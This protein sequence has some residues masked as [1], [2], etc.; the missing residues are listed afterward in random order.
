MLDLKLLR[1]R[2][3]AVR[4]ALA[5]RGD[6]ALLHD[7][8]AAD[9]RRRKIVHQVELKQQEHNQR[10][11][12]IGKA[13][14]DDRPALL[15]E[16]KRLK[17]EIEA[18]DPQVK[19]AEEQLDMVLAR[20][21]NLPH[22]SVPTGIS[23]DDNVE[24]RRWG[25]PT[26][27]PDTRD[28]LDIGRELGVI[29]TERAAWTSGSRFGYLL[30]G[31]VH[32]EFALVR[33]AMDRLEPHGFTPVIPPVLVRREA[34]FGAGA[35]PGDDAQYY[36]VQDGLY[37]TGT[38]E[39]ALAAIHAEEELEA[40]D[41]PIRYMA[42]SSCFR[43]EAGAYGRDTR[44]IFRVHQFDKVEM[45]S[46]AHPDHSWD[47]HG[48]LVARQEELLQSLGLPYRAM[49]VCTGELGAPAAKKID[50][51]AWFPGQRRYREVM[52]CS[53]CTDFQARRLKVRMK[54]PGGKRILH[55]LNGTAFAIGRTIAA[56]MENYQEPS[57]AVVI[58][59]PLRPYMPAGLSRIDRR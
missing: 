44:G 48:F 10:S 32:L 56:I 20:V 13:L 26:E 1:E 12:Q 19:E 57:G 35:L 29:D 51:E 37:L 43:R 55:T 27:R 58:P 59:E 24:L 41:L 38:S 16:A 3:E 15:D 49:N 6:E 53:N 5:R 4:D 25:A 36:V 23:D 39:Q 21:P 14:A 9:E 52:S 18:L 45:F 54:G 2:P 30:G 40:G 11:K 8:M 47:E 22:E 7:V 34:M 17:S 28:H 31:L 33:Y 50:L 42:F 46:F